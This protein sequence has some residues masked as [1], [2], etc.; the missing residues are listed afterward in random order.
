VSTARRRFDSCHRHPQCGVLARDVSWL[1]GDMARPL[2]PVSGPL[3]QPDPKPGP[4]EAEGDEPMS[5]EEVRARAAQ[6]DK[7]AQWALDVGR[8]EF[9]PDSE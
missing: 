9:E 6:G 7:L 2:P 3:G 8:E 4:V 1:T 5:E